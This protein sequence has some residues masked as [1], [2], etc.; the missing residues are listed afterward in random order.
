MN[1]SKGQPMITEQGVQIRPP[2]RM[3]ALTELHKLVEK[4]T[5]IQS[6]LRFLDSCAKSEDCWP[7][8]Q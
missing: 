8:F 5:A 4:Q 3:I 2:F 7:S 1:L 6:D